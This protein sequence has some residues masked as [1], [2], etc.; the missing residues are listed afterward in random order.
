[1]SFSRIPFELAR[2]ELF[3]AAS[4]AITGLVIRQQEPPAPLPHKCHTDQKVKIVFKLG[5]LL[6]PL[7]I[8]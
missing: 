3:T 8:V 7:L 4:W 5:L 6:Q 1:M 2:S